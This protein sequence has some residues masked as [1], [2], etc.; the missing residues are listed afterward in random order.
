MQRDPSSRNIDNLAELLV[1][2]MRLSLIFYSKETLLNCSE[3]IFSLIESSK[4][5]LIGWR[6][7]QNVC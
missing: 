5:K 1:F 3:T 2:L 4:K 7:G 6:I